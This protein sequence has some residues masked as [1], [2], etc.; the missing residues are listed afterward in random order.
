M[1]MTREGEGERSVLAVY[2]RC[3]RLGRVKSRLGKEIGEELARQF[4]TLC[5]DLL[6]KE[7]PF[8]KGTYSA[9]AICPSDP[10]DL[11]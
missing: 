9:V 7:L 5:L 11:H 1:E 6:R 2:C 4:Y 8:L 10:A 3:P